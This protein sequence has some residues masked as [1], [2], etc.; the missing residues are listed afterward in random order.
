VEGLAYGR[1]RRR[2]G[3]GTRWLTKSEAAE[4]ARVSD[5]TLERLCRAG[6]LR[7]YRVRAR[8]LFDKGEL[9]AMILAR[10]VV[11]AAG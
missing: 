7:R 6:A 2:A 1:S 4:Y 9:D 11:P 10:P 3:G 5:S 8:V